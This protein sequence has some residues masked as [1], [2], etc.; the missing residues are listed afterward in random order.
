MSDYA[1]FPEQELAQLAAYHEQLAQ[2]A[3]YSWTK[4]LHEDRAK[5]CRD[6]IACHDALR[7][8]FLEHK[9]GLNDAAA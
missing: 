2:Q 6:A 3:I 9:A 5:A 1:P 4:H 8:R 7:T